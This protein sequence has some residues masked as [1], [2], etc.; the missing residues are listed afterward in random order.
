[1]TRTLGGLDNCHWAELRRG[2]TGW[3]LWAYNLGPTTRVEPPPS[4]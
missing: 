1:V 3:R 2:R 4:T